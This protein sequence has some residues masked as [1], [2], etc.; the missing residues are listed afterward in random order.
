MSDVNV[1]G[2]WLGSQKPIGTI[3]LLAGGRDA[4]EFRFSTEYLES[5][6]RPVLGQMFEDDLVAAHSARV[7]LPPFFSNLLP[8]GV[9]RELLARRA[10]VSPTREFFLLAELGRDLPGAVVIQPLTPLVSDDGPIG[11]ELASPG[12]SLDHPLRFSVAGLQLKFSVAQD[13]GRWVLP[14]SGEGG[15]WLLKVPHPEFRGVPQNEFSMMRWA[16]LVGLDVAEVQLVPLSSVGGLPGELRFSES[17][18]LLVR[19]FDRT[20]RQRIHMEDFLQVIGRHPD[21]RAK[22]RATNLDSIGKLLLRLENRET[23]DLR[24]LVRRV[25][26]NAAIGNGDAHLKNW[27]LL[28]DVPTWPRLSPAYDLVSTVHYLPGETQFALNIAKEKRFAALTLG[29]FRAFA[30]HVDVDADLVVSWVKEVVEGIRTTWAEA[31]RTLPIE[32]DLTRTLEK[33]MRGVPVLQG[34]E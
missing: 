20:D 24:E 30:R 16:G 19:R 18:A 27:S 11:R 13:A 34:I 33:H 7:R 15:K 26:F 3:R 32:P 21:D 17:E 22:Y 2:V 25:V 28:Y 23:R 31:K 10:G 14:V 9:L 4:T 29:V 8:E 5:V 6:G 1:L 12:P